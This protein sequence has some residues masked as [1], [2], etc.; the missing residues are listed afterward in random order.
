ML[1]QWSL[2]SCTFPGHD[3]LSELILLKELLEVWARRLRE[4]EISAYRSLPVMLPGVCQCLSSISSNAFHG[5]QVQKKVRQGRLLEI[6]RSSHAFR[7]KELNLE[8]SL[9][10]KDFYGMMT[11]KQTPKW[12]MMCAIDRQV[13]AAQRDR[14]ERPL[15]LFACG[16]VVCVSA[17]RR[18]TQERETHAKH[19]K[20]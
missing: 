14:R 12:Q 5:K 3:G 9:L 17:K 7:H 1:L 10:L 18:N 2:A 16:N 13:A 11:C 20:A 4:A 15:P 6:R 19:E 8:P